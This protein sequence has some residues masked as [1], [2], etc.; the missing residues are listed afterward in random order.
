MIDI[1]KKKLEAG[2]KFLDTNKS[3]DGVIT[4]SNGLQYKVLNEGDGEKPT[5][6]DRQ[7][8]N[9]VQG[10]NNASR[11]M[12]INSLRKPATTLSEHKI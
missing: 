3:K 8:V 12:R 9:L 2:L 10:R 5:I 1:A 11:Q 6:K 7:N 4:L